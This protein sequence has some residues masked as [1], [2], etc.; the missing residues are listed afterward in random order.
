MPPFI[1]RFKL[2]FLVHFC[3]QP[4]LEEIAT[5]L[6]NAFL[7]EDSR[8]SQVVSILE[9][10]ANTISWHQIFCRQRFHSADGGCHAL[11]EATHIFREIRLDLEYGDHLAV[12]C[13]KYRANDM[14]GLGWEL[15]PE[16]Q[17]P[18]VQAEIKW[19]IG[20]TTAVGRHENLTQ[21]DHGK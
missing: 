2:A 19:K 13:Q 8:K 17:W 15:H 10:Y 21:I 14:A 5:T 12:R 6:N 9:E 16:V 11:V 18:Q 1:I 3:T 7:D 4:A 20:R